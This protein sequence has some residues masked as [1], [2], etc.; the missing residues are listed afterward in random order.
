MTMDHSGHKAA[1][2]PDTAA[3]EPTYTCPM[4]PEVR[5]NGP[6]SCPKCGMTLLPV[7]GQTATIPAMKGDA[8]APAMPAKMANMPGMAHG[9][10][11]P[12]EDMGDMMGDAHRAMLWPHYVVIMLG[13]WMITAPFTLGYLSDFAPDANQ[14]RVMADRGLTSFAHRNMLMTLNDMGSGLLIVFFGYL[15]ANA[16]RS[17]PWAQ[18]A[19]AVIGGW[20]LLAPLAIWTPLP[21]A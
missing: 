21:E 9:A 13:F 3:G 2:Q 4:H 18:W 20:L 17:Y 10:A 12:S 7:A 19:N 15:S 8:M 11:A 6:G 16:Q 1:A 5:Q 14:L